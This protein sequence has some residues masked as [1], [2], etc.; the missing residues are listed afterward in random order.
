MI[1]T[2]DKKVKYQDQD[3]DD[4]DYYGIKDIENLFNDDVDDNI[5][6]KQILVDTSFLKKNRIYESKGDKG[7]SFHDYSIFKRFNKYLKG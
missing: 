3:R 6:Y 7:I 4:L 2:L 5:Y 1:R